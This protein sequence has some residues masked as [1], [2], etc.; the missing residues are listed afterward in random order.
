MSW[1][2]IQDQISVLL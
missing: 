1:R 2:K